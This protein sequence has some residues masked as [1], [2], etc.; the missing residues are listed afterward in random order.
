MLPSFLGGTTAPLLTV[1]NFEEMTEGK[2][3]FVKVGLGM[4]RVVD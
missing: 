3:I 2:A 4:K 1:E